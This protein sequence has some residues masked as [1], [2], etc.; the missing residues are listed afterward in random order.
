MSYVYFQINILKACYEMVTF[1]KI[2]A[3]HH[4]HQT[5]LNEARF[6][7]NAT[8]LNL[9]LLLICTCF[10]RN[11]VTINLPTFHYI[12][13]SRKDSTGNKKIFGRKSKVKKVA[14]GEQL[15]MDVSWILCM[16][17]RTCSESVYTAE[18]VHCKCSRNVC[19]I[20]LNIF[21]HVQF[22]FRECDVYSCVLYTMCKLFDDEVVSFQQPCLFHFCCFF[23]CSI[24]SVF[25]T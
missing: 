9:V 2:S 6:K 1:T 8:D 16:Y 5:C 19:A 23:L 20:F 14:Y 12:S 3:I 11:T 7:F 18:C 25:F 17:C 4:G 15:E 13:F 21:V 24:C 22:M 10:L